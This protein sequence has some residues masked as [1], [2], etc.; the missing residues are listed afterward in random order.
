V[1]T[2]VE[3]RVAQVGDS[4][5][6]L[7][8]PIVRRGDAPVILIPILR[9]SVIEG[10]FTLADITDTEPFRKLGASLAANPDSEL[11]R[12]LVSARITVGADGI[13]RTELVTSGAADRVQST[14][15]LF[16]EEELR[17]QLV[18]MVIGSSAVPA[19][20]D[21]RTA[22]APL[23]D[24]FFTG[25][26]NSAVALLSAN[27][28][29]AGARL[30]KLVAEEQRRYMAAPSFDEVVEL[31]SV[32]PRGRRTSPSPATA[33][34]HS[35]RLRRTKDGNGRCFRWNGSTPGL[36]VPSQTWW[37]TTPGCV[38]GSGSIRASSRSSGMGQEYN[39]DLIVIGLDGTHWVVE[40][41]MEKEMSSEDVKGKRDAARRWANY[42]NA[43]E[44]VGASWRYLLAAESDVDTAKG[45]W[46]ALKK[47]GG[48]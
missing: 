5:L 34:A 32:P 31:R 20:K 40:V 24:A 22:I 42:V 13:R 39:P 23:M 7:Q 48:E 28:G 27:L 33:S 21:Q 18:D 12:T 17:T 35:A 11:S 25:L 26:G 30:V 8:Q 36:S 4:V 19:R 10:G 45:S 29:R 41:K 2:T 1:V 43:D 44:K 6:K 47:L 38:A 46:S 37:M 14:P 16:A 3:Q 15:T 9:M